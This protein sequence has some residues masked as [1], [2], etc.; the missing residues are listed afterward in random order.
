MILLLDTDFIIISNVFII[1]SNVYNASANRDGN[2]V[3]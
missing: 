3:Y 2:L 1:I